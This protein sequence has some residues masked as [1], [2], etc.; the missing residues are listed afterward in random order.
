MDWNYWGNFK[1]EFIKRENYFE[2][3]EKLSK[4]SEIVVIKSVKR[5]GKSSIA[6]QFSREKSKENDIL[7]INLEDPRFL[8]KM[9][10]KDLHKNFET[11]LK[12]VNPKVPKYVIIDEV[13]Y[14]ENGKGL[15][16]TLV[17][18]RE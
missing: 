6:Y 3:L 15:Q 2:K 9:E 5:S 12:R 14:V 17:N 11:F 7:I 10:A 1:R 13:Q 16:D 8:T 18:Q 4:G